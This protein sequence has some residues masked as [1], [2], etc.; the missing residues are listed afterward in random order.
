MSPAR[1]EKKSGRLSERR[2]HAR[3]AGVVTPMR[4]RAAEEAP[5]DTEEAPEPVVEAAPVP[6]PAPEP[7]PAPE[8]QATA[9]DEKNPPPKAKA[10]SKP[11][12]KPKA[13]TPAAKAVDPKAPAAGEGKAKRAPKAHPRMTLTVSA[14]VEA[15]LQDLL[16][17]ELEVTG[18][19]PSLWQCYDR[20]LREFLPTP[21]DAEGQDLAVEDG[22]A[23]YT[24]IATDTRR[25][26]ASLRRARTPD[27]THIPL[28]WFYTE[29]VRRYVAARQAELA[30]M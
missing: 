20:A 8:P 2:N 14:A 9:G 5:V 13:A 10:P 27:G 18:R 11:K 12:P 4:Q 28:Q 22:T 23:I 3:S 29:A 25:G 26:L 1:F 21:A 30:A 17:D 6:E 16:Y 15:D 24:N 19:M 7:A